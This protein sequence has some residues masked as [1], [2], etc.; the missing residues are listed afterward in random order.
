MM[1]LMFLIIFG[2]ATAFFATQNTGLVHIT[3]ANITL[4]SI[5]LY[6][7]V[8]G[9]MLLGILI[10]WLVKTIEFISSSLIIHEKDTQLKT[11]LKTNESLSKEKAGLLVENQH[12][13]E[14]LQHERTIEENPKEE[15]T[16]R[17]SFL[18]SVRHNFHQKG[19]FI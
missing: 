11:A 14:E 3:I 12:L 5:P 2:L 1:S 17:P 8:I 10:S 6:V 18:E 19:G 9:S 16:Q 15:K 13:K 4:S 7:I